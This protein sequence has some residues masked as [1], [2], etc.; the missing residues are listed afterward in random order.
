MDNQD[1]KK[2]TPILHHIGLATGRFKG[3]VS[4]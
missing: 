2:I 4:W 3:I 1:N